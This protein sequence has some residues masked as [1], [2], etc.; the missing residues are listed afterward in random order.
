MSTLQQLKQKMGLV[1]VPPAKPESAAVLPISKKQPSGNGD[2][3][4]ALFEEANAAGGQA[5]R[6]DAQAVMQT[7]IEQIN[8]D[9]F[10]SHEGGKVRVFQE[11]FDHELRRKTIISFSP[12]DFKTLMA[13][14]TC[15]AVDG[16]GNTRRKPL[17]DVWMTSPARREYLKGMALLP[18]GDTPTGVYNLWSGWGVEPREGD[19]SQ[20]IE[21]IRVVICAGDERMLR[22]VLGWMAACVQNPAR[23]AEVAIVLCGKKGTGKGTF[24]RW[25]LSIFGM[26][27]LHVLQRRHLVGNFNAHLRSLCFIFADEAFFAGDHEGQ[28]VLKGIITEDQ[29]T[30]ERKGVD[31]FGVRN[32]LKVLMA[33]NESWVV[34]ASE[35]ERR[36]CVLEVSAV[37]RGDHDYFGELDHHMRNGGLAAL[38]HFLLSYDLSKFNI[39]AVPNSEALERQKILSLPPIKAWLYERLWDGRFSAAEM[40]WKQEHA[41]DQIASYVSEYV[42]QRG[43]RYVSTDPRSIGVVLHEVFPHLRESRESSGT[44]RRLWVFPPLTDARRQF[45]EHIGIEFSSWPDEEA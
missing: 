1:E 36:Y 41:R 3:R 26:H 19:V 20:P 5:A 18:E 8:E 23:Q 13:T 24:G 4:L 28:S 34:P 9:H 25:L 43:L 6:S 30:I 29:I 16:N 27:G 42:S 39:R 37:R 38:L 7:E 14:R 35:D 10:V 17:A 44:R 11:S 33:T 21:F 22:Y 15:V 2:D 12:Q 40:S 32:R 31:A 45:A